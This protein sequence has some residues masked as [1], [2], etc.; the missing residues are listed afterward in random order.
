MKVY[1]KIILAIVFVAGLSL[2][3]IGIQDS[4]VISVMI[5][6]LLTLLGIGIYVYKKL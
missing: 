1:E 4:S 5:G 3:G 6:S 2:I